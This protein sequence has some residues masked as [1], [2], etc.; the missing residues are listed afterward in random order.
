MCVCVFIMY[1]YI[2][3]ESGYDPTVNLIEEH[4]DYFYLN[5]I[6]YNTPLKM[7]V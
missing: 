1:V 6:H 5:C 3:G 7:S 2:L 4:H